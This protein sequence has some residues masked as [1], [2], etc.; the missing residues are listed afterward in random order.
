MS[1]EAIITAPAIPVRCLNWKEA[2]LE[3]GNAKERYNELEFP[4][5]LSAISLIQRLA[6]KYSTITF[7]ITAPTFPSTYYNLN[8]N[9]GIYTCDRCYAW[10][11]TMTFKVHEYLKDAKRRD[12]LFRQISEM[13]WALK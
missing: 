8:F 1:D 6:Y 5:T 10:S 3:L 12:L 13:P 7:I 9:L 11:D 2:Q 4:S